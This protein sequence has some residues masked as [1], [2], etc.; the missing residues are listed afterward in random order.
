MGSGPAFDNIE[1]PK[2]VIQVGD[3]C[4]HDVL[5]ISDMLFSTRGPGATLQCI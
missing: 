3:P 4:S 1:Q 5:E 2:Q